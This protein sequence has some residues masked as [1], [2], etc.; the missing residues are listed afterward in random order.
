MTA[1]SRPK[2][3]CHEDDPA[4]VTVRDIR[5]T[6]LF[7]EAEAILAA[8]RQP[9]RNR[10][11]DVADIHGR[12]D[13]N[14]VV[15]TASI[16][17]DLAAAP[18]TVVAEI[19][20]ADGGLAVLTHGSAN[21]R[22]PRH[23]PTGDHI[24]LLVDQTR[25]GD[26]Q[27]ALL[28]RAT[29]ELTPAP[30]LDG[31]I[32][33]F[34]WSPDGMRILVGVSGRGADL[35][36]GEGG[37]ASAG[38]G[39]S[40]AE[41]MPQVDQGADAHQ[42]RSVQLFDTRTGRFSDVTPAGLNIWEADWCG[43]AAIAAIVSDA[44]DEGAWYAARLVLIDCATRCAQPLLTTDMQ[45]G[46]VAGSPD[47]RKIAC[48][49]AACSDRKFVAGDLVIVDVA[50]AA[51]DR[52]DTAS[53]DITQVAWLTADRLL[54]AGHRGP[55][56][57]FGRID[58]KPLRFEQ[59][60]ASA[61]W[62]TGGIYAHGAALDE[63][64]RFALFLEQF[65]R[66]PALATLGDDGTMTH[67]HRFVPEADANH[68]LRRIDAVK[69]EAPDGLTIDGWM[70]RPVTGCAPYP[71][72]TWIHGGPIAHW[73]QRWLGRGNLAALHLL[74]RGVALFLPNPRGSAGRGQAFARRVIG[75]TGGADTGDI[76]SGIDQ[77]VASGLADQRRL[78]V[79][80]G[81]YGGFMTCW[82]V[83]QDRRFAAAVPYSPYVNQLSMRFTAN[84]P[85]FSARFVAGGFETPGGQYW[86]R[87]PLTFVGAV[88]TPVLT[89]G[90]ALDRC[91][92]VSEAVQF[93]KAL[94][95]QG[96][97]SVL[98]I[99]PREGHGIRKVPA[100]IDF[101]ARVVAWFDRYLAGP[102]VTM[103]AALPISAA[104]RD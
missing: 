53:T 41:W 8:A 92:P 18:R 70:L 44:P 52:V 37:I 91:T 59:L 55:E 83:A 35:A 56:T 58:T 75:D 54:V 57:V 63:Y 64:G 89:V 65:D 82:L 24:A 22:A 10:I 104:P 40:T 87:S 94:R 95:E 36:G 81:S 74:R 103:P 49:E 4:S 1:M 48:V 72:V 34:R 97:Y 6:A 20:L 78:G 28:D 11:F 31:W 66:P 45:L 51:V 25:S 21:Y 80:G 98:L 5:Q 9:G 73:R 3:G 61:E 17:E 32:E 33:Y 88:T 99:Y 43:D 23:A 79:M 15:F 12:A 71:L 30:A 46:A 85:A 42:W 39:D 101:S 69:W 26:W 14:A 86:S 68:V 102:D 77:L 67:I 2:A 100:T 60:W 27:L 19:D 47:S 13:G 62:T 38:C 29:L 90:G 50:T 96:N 84:I 76:L 16:A 93:H 7:R